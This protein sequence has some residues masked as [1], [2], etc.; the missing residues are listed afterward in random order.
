MVGELRDL[1]TIDACLKAAETGHLV[2]STLHTNC[3]TT[4][5]GRIV[6]YFAPEAQEIVRQRLADILV[7]T[8]SLRL[9]N[10][11][12]GENMVPAVEVMRMTPAIQACI[13]EGRMVDIPKHIEKGR[14]QYH[15]QTLDQHLVTLCQNNVVSLEEALQA[16]SS[17]DLERNMMVT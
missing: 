16:S 17:M 13:R 3:A 10:T 8:V 12:D 4:T 2:I 7:A 6:S 9:I 11:I 1:E 5:I 14:E 15:M